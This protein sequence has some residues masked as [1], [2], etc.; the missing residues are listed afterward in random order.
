MIVWWKKGN[1]LWSTRELNDTG[2][3]DHIL[4]PRAQRRYGGRPGQLRLWIDN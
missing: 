3:M 1:M 2:M 4:I